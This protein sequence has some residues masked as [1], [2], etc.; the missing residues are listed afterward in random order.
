MTALLPFAAAALPPTEAMLAERA[1]G[2]PQAKVTIVEYSSLT[3]PH[4]AEFH[5]NVL[6]QIKAEY[7]DTG[8]VRW[9]FRDFP[10]DGRA[11]GAA[12]IARCVPAERYFGFI[13]ML[14]RDQQAWARS[15]DPLTDL[16]VR[17]QLAGLAPADVDACL[18][19]KVLL[20]GIQT[21]AQEAQKQDGIDGTPSFRMNGQKIAPN[22]SFDEFKSVITPA[23]GK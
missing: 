14:F 11:M 16:K 3:C 5:Q 1:L 13:D 4:C 21:R 15:T 18:A 7:I 20:Q 10:L 8:M 12:M 19:D 17:A 22:H 23:L 2:D 9:V 6:P